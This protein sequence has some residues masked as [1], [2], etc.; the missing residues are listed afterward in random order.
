MKD[1]ASLYKTTNGGEAWAPVYTFAEASKYKSISFADNDNGALLIGV[2][3]LYI[4]NDGGITFES[5][6]LNDKLV[7]INQVD[8]VDN[9][10]WISAISM[11][12][13][14]PEQKLIK[15]NN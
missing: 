10:I 14:I 1:E 15:I 2:T 6:P 3:A 11:S 5:S 12:D 7:E 4:T 13:G 9:C 8:C